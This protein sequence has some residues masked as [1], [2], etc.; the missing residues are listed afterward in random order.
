MKLSMKGMASHYLSVYLSLWLL[1]LTFSMN[2]VCAY[3]WILAMMDGYE[4]LG[5][6]VDV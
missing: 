4:S 5:M 3:T 6:I 1:R 2:P